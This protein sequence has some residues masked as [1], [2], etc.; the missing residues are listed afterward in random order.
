MGV[1]GSHKSQNCW[2][3]RTHHTAGI[4]WRLVNSQL[5]VSSLV[6]NMQAGCF[7]NF[8]NSNLWLFSE[9][10]VT[11]NCAPSSVQVYHRLDEITLIS[12]TRTFSLIAFVVQIHIYL[13]CGGDLAAEL[14]GKRSQHRV[15]SLS[16][17]YSKSRDLLNTASKG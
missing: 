17:E 9:P 12:Y 3:A 10:K 13:E 7:H 14:R 6:C 8:S 1:S 5:L 15:L 4:P 11:T 16:E 2:H